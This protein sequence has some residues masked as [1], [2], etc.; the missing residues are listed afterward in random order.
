VLNLLNVIIKERI[1]KGLVSVIFSLVNLDYFFFPLLWHL[2]C[3]LY[4]PLHLG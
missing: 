4:G 3:N 1:L 2:L